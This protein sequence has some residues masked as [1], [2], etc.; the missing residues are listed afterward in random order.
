MTVRELYQTLDKAIPASLSCEWDNDGLMCSPDL[1]APVKR[2]LLTLDVSE[3][4]VDYA[5]A[6][7]CDLIISH[8]PMIFRPLTSLTEENFTARKALKCIMNGISVFSFHTRLD[9][10]EGGVNDR[11]ADMLGLADITSFGDAETPTIGRIG[12][13]ETT[14]TEAFSALVKEK[15]GVPSLQTVDF[16]K[17]IRCVALVGGDGKDFLKPALRAGADLYLTG[18]LSY[19]SMVDAADLGLQ[20]ME[21]G[22]FFTEN[23][24]LSVLDEMITSAYPEAEIFTFHSDPVIYR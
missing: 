18:S 21:A 6:N 7:K 22:H 4:S 14:S 1:S 24:V 16:G 15:L 17:D 5:V 2:I 23:P 3:A 12:T 8:H 20:V 9:I 11:L 19:N 13:V 10:V